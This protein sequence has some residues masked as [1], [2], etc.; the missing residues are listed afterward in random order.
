M[1]EPATDTT[2]AAQ[3]PKPDAPQ[4]DAEFQ[5]HLHGM[6]CAAE[7]AKFGTDPIA[8]EAILGAA[9]PVPVHFAGRAFTPLTTAQVYAT[10]LATNVVGETPIESFEESLITFYA[11]AHHTSCFLLCN[12]PDVTLPML[13]KEAFEAAGALPVHELRAFM[14]WFTD[15]LRILNGGHAPAAPDTVPGKPSAPAAASTPSSPTTPP[16]VPPPAGL[17]TP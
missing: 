17:P 1:T 11:V 16:E 2:P 13:R 3:P 12:A 5:A 15:Q 10:V 7:A 4:R 8:A 9:A 14:D 6:K